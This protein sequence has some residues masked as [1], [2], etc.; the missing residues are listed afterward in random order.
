MEAKH[1]RLSQAF[2]SRLSKPRENV[3][4]ERIMIGALSDTVGL[5]GWGRSFG[6]TQCGCQ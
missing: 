4:V 6:V 5:G 2:T 1:R 3:N